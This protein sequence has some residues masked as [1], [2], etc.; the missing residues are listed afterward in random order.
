MK[1]PPQYLDRLTTPAMPE[2][3][4]LYQQS[5]GGYST[6]ILFQNGRGMKFAEHCK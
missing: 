2:V 6:P 4:E 3:E 5:H 1:V